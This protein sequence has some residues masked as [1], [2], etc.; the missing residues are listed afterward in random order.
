MVGLKTPADWLNVAGFVVGIL[1]LFAAYWQWRSSR[2]VAEV[3]YRLRSDRIMGPFDPYSPFAAIPGTELA[4]VY[5][6]EE[7][8]AANR[9]FLAIWNRGKGV[10]EDTSL[11]IEDPLRVE[12]EGPGFFLAEP[13]VLSTSRDSCGFHA[14]RD[15]SARG[16]VFLNFAFLAQGDGALIELLFSGPS[17]AVHL[18]GDFKSA[19]RPRR[20]GPLELKIGRGRRD[21]FIERTVAVLREM[22]S[23]KEVFWMIGAYTFL[24]YLVLVVRGDRPRPC[25]LPYQGFLR[26][27]RAGIAVRR[28]QRDAR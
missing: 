15:P 21:A 25:L 2:N 3:Y 5:H 23:S 6:D 10:L 28:L 18:K 16:K 8:D 11:L 13:R 24:L 12:V 7:I 9:A 14:S 26:P 4:L 17:Q 19:K 22:R 1:G 20:D 27:V